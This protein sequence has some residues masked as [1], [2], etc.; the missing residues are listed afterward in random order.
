MLV[1]ATVVFGFLLAV[2]FMRER[3]KEAPGHFHTC[4][5]CNCDRKDE[6]FVTAGS[7]GCSTRPPDQISENR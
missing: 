4:G 2:F 7:K 1:G 3:S 6:P 5:H